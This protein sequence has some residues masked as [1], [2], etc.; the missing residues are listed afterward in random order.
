MILIL[1]YPF[2]HDALTMVINVV[3]EFKLTYKTGQ[4]VRMFRIHINEG[5]ATRRER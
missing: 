4:G 1:S 3:S 2:D 5:E